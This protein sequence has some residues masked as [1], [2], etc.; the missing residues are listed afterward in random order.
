MRSLAAGACVLVLTLS[1]A[2][3]AQEGEQPPAP[4]GGDH[5]TDEHGGHGHAVLADL[6]PGERKL[7]LEAFAHVY[8]KCPSENWSKTLANCPDGCADEQ[9][10]E[11]MHAVQAGWSTDAI[12]EEQV[13][14]YGPRAN[15]DPSSAINGSLLVVAGLLAGAAAAGA[16]LA[17]WNRASDVRRA[18]AQSAREGDPPSEPEIS[19]VE[20]ELQEID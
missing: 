18:A 3:F 13:R 5:A 1:A 4:G 12:V 16:V 6:S 17:S 19:A 11:I 10:Q 15:A 2:A 20:R 9:K 14:K 7:A 8:C